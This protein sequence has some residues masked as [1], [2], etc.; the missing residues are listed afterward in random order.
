MAKNGLLCESDSSLFRFWTK[1]RS[2]PFWRLAS[3]DHIK[4]N[5]SRDEQGGVVVEYSPQSD[6]SPIPLFACICF[7]CNETVSFKAISPITQSNAM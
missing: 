4:K 6:I 3:D 1:M 7:A 2:L 5:I